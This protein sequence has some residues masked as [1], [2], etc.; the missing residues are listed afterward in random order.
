MKKHLTRFKFQLIC[1]YI[2]TIIFFLDSNSA[3][4][5]CWQNIQAGYNHTLAIKND[6]TLWA[7][8]NNSNGKLGDGTVFD[9]NIPT[10]IGVA[11]NWQSIATGGNHSLAIKSDGTL[12]AWGNNNLGQLGDGTSNNMALPTQIGLGTNW[13]KVSAGADHS[14]AI[15]TDGTLWAWGN[16]SWGQLGDGTNIDK[17]SPSQIGVGSTWQSI[18]TGDVHTIAIKSNGSMWACGNNYNGQCGDGTNIDKNVLTQIGIATNWQSISASWNNSSAINTNGSLF[19]WG[20][21]AYGQLGDG[22]NVDK[23]IP[24]QI[25]IETTWQK[26]ETGPFTLAIKTNGSIWA[27][28]SNYYG[29]LGDGTNIDKNYFIPIGMA[30]NWQTIANGNHYYSLA[31]KTDGTLWVWGWNMSGQLGDGSFTDKNT[32]TYIAGA[33]C[34]PLPVHL[35]SFN[36]FKCERTNVCFTWESASEHNMSC[37]NVESSTDGIYFTSIATLPA[38]NEIKN[39]YYFSDLNP[40]GKLYYRLK[41]IDIDQTFS[42]SEIVE[43]NYDKETAIQI[44]PNPANTSIRINGLNGLSIIELTNM[45]GQVISSIRTI[46]NIIEMPTNEMKNGIYQ[47]KISNNQQVQTEKVVIQH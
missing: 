38:K 18:A 13:Q 32:P 16:N 23:N 4:A 22:T 14:I 34:F 30:T 31:I 17:N 35:L 5:Q 12:W 1:C 2:I 25:G 44:F 43:I 9:K 19:T 10:Q 21:N 36:A 26:V 33:G 6:G 45:Q 20:W 29:S 37:Y 11:N 46:S 41:M 3:L 7:W 28:G 39:N 47:L 40:I 15:K 24:T 27:S 8:G 42:Y